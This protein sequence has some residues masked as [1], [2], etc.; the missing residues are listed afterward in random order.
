MD[1]EHNALGRPLLVLL[2]PCSACHSL[3]AAGDCNTLCGLIQI[4]FDFS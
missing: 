3:M 2:V 1:L 4:M